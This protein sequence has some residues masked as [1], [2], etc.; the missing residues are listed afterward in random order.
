MGIDS[1][2]LNKETKEYFD[3]RG[4]WRYSIEEMQQSIREGKECL[5]S[6]LSNFGH[7]PSK[8]YRSWVANK[9]IKLA[10][11]KPEN[12]IICHDDFSYDELSDGYSWYDIF[13]D[14]G[15]IELPDI[16]YFTFEREINE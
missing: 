1:K 6:L 14:K 4:F 2:I 8:E 15:Y 13:P 11:G 7:A 5:C 16:Y 9:I 10:N 12:I 3:V